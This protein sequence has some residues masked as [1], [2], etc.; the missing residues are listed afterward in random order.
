MGAL[1]GLAYTGD[2]DEQANMGIAVGDYDND[3]AT[4]LFITSFATEHKTLFHNDGKGIFTDVSYPAGVGEATIPYLGMATFFIDYNNDGWKDIFIVNGQLYPEVDKY[5]P[6]EHYLQNPQLFEN[7]KNGKFREVSREVGVG[8]M[9]IGG[10]G[11]AFCDYDNDGDIDVAITTIGGRPLLL[12]NDGGNTAGHWLQVKTV[13]TK[14]NR[15]GIGALVKVAAGTLTQFDRV[16]TGGTWLSG[17]DMRLHFGL[18]QHEEADWVEVHWPS[19]MIDRLK[20]VDANQVVVVREGDGQILSH[21]RPA[22]RRDSTSKPSTTRG[23]DR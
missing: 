3:G 18:G 7:L 8:A 16:R 12:R 15:D 17:N 20:H 2:G 1:A 4:D 14:S 9:R 13:G 6:D 21:Y 22:T 11:G 5:F 23:V 19:G 10:R